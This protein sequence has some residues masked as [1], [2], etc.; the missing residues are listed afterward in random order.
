[1]IK[2][3]IGCGAILQDNNPL[4]EGYTT[5]LTNDLCKRCFRMK[6]YGEYEF[7][8]KDNL[9]YVKILNNINLQIEPEKFIAIT[10]PNGSGKSTLAKIIMGIEKPDSGTILFN[11]QD[12][13]NMPINERAKLGMSFAFQQPV[14][15]KGITVY[16]LLKIAAKK[17]INRAEA[18]EIL[19]KVGLCAKEYVD[20]EVNGSLSGGEL[21]RIEIATVVLRK[22]MLTIFDEPEAGIDLW[23]FNNLIEIFE[24]LS[25]EIKGSTIIISHQERILKIAD[26]IILM[27]SG[28][29]AKIGTSD[30]ILSSEIL[31]KECCKMNKK[32]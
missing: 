24:E 4:I 13:T 15:F 27:K 32:C 14:K 28:K 11:G 30:E 1:M 31:S 6:N 8:T 5:V 26:E 23:S 7:V 17:R 10:G 25:R 22:A 2:K 21:K 18:C 29:I 19:S 16:D 12:I 20:R 3:C 9:E